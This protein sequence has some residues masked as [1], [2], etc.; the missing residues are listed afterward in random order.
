MDYEQAKVQLEIQIT[1]N[2][3]RLI[4]DRANLSLLE[5]ILRQTERQLERD[6]VARANGVIGELIYLR[7]QLAVETARYNLSAAEDAYITALRDFLVLLG[8]ENQDVDSGFAL[9]GRIETYPLEPDPEGLIREYLPKRPDIM[10]QLQTIERLELTKKQNLH[11]ARTPSLDLS[12]QWR[13]GSGNAGLSGD[14]TD[15][16]SGSLT[17]RVPIDG[18]IPGTRSN[19][20]L[21]S[22]DTDLEKARLDLKNT[23]TAAAAQIHSLTVNLKNSWHSLE[24]ARLR[25]RLAERTYELTETG[26]RNGTVE[27][28]VLEDARSDLADARQ[29]LLQGELAYQNLILD[30]AAALN[31]DWK[32]FSRSEP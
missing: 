12:A 28:R 5:E 29:R 11:S 18:W 8:I 30:L 13:G 3:Y 15:N 32:T 21:M 10:S 6:R 20:T 1:R 16:L 31:A 24:I 9:E 25:V 19:Q 26:F 27:S 7:S 4:T 22:A 17:L 2:F 23:E 14:F